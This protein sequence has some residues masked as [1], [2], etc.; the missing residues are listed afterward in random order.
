M[1]FELKRAMP[2]FRNVLREAPSLFD[3]L[4]RVGPGCRASGSSGAAA[5]SLDAHADWASSQVRG[6]EGDHK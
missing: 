1:F 5:F 6:Y 2:P 4:F 3:S